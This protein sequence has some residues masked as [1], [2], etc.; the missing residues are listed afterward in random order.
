MV[1]GRNHT[2]LNYEKLMTVGHRVTV[3]KS[4]GQEL[5]GDGNMR[6]RSSYV[7]GGL[8]G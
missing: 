1:E 7:G 8:E 6:N 3:R 4:T 5:E 2:L